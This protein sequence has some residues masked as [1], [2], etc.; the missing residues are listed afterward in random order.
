MFKDYTLNFVVQKLLFYP[1]CRACEQTL[2]RPGTFCFSCLKSLFRAGL[3][4]AAALFSY[5]GAIPTVIRDLKREEGWNTPKL[6]MRFLKRSHLEQWQD[7]DFVTVAPSKRPHKG[8]EQCA[9][10]IARKLNIPFLSLLEKDRFRSQHDHEAHTRMDTKCF[11]RLKK[12]QTVIDK[13]ILVLDDVL[14][15]GTTLDMCAHVLRANGAKEVRLFSLAHKLLP[16]FEG[17]RQQS[18]QKGDEIS[19][20]LF[21]LAM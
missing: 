5:E 21:H 10:E 6:L 13:S 9:Q 2:S 16:S 12:N 7:I 15:T 18:N 20:L 1:V 11:V 3:P 17:E 19:P 8:L 14:T 4:Q